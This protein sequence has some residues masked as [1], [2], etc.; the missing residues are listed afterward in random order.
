ME[1]FNPQPMQE[2]LAGFLIQP[3]ACPSFDCWDSRIITKKIRH[4]VIFG[5]IAFGSIQKTQLLY[6]LTMVT[7]LLPSLPMRNSSMIS[8]RKT[9]K[10]QIR[11]H[12]FSKGNTALLFVKVN[13]IF[14]IL[15]QSH[16]TIQFLSGYHRCR[17]DALSMVIGIGSSTIA[18]CAMLRLRW[19]KKDLRHM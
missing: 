5:S 9:Q 15:R 13:T 11:C 16:S 17:P 19:R 10:T 1:K 12:F 8:S 14:Q 2:D 6:T 7:P 18:S 4:A 3:I